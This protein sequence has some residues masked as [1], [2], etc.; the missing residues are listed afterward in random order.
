MI[1]TTRR[2]PLP[3]PA[4]KP[5]TQEQN[6]NKKK[7][8]EKKNWKK[9]HNFS[10]F[11]VTA[12]L[13]SGA[14]LLSCF[15]FKWVSQFLLPLLTINEFRSLWTICHRSQLCA[16][17]CVCVCVWT[18][19][20]IEVVG[21]TRNRLFHGGSDD[22][23]SDDG[24]GDL[25]VFLAEQLLSEGFSVSIRVGTVADQSARQ[26][27]W[28]SQLLLTS[29]LVWMYT[30]EIDL[31]DLWWHWVGCRLSS[32]WFA[33]VGVVASTSDRSP[34]RYFPYPSC[35]TLSTRESIPAFI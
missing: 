8:K 28:L 18:C 2:K 35:C 12:I 23:G 14:L 31:T 13:F 15:L 16:C 26:R 3:A 25:T 4:I 17:M 11:P 1:C 19:G 21:P 20:S 29:T 30:N 10:S 6:K 33:A 9:W 24:D 32:R 34:P 7:K 22:G 5:W 27:R